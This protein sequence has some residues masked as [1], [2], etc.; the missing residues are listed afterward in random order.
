MKN[1]SEEPVMMTFGGHL[2]VLRKMLFRIMAVVL[3]LGICVF[4]F[5]EDTF[6]ILLAPRKWDFVTYRSIESLLNWMGVE[7]HFSEYHIDLINTELSAQ[8]MTHISSSV[9]LAL[10]GAS[11]YVVYELFCFITPALYERERR[12]SVGIIIATYLLFAVGILMSYF[13]IFP[14]SF[15]FLGTYQV[16]ASIVNTITLSSYISTFTML[17]LIMGLVFQLPVLAFFLAK[18]GLISSCI[19]KK[20]RKHAIVIIMIIAAVITPPDIFTL[21]LVT[22]PIYLLYEVSI[23]IVKRVENISNRHCGQWRDGG[24]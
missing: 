4:A 2:D 17:T 5:K 9:Y 8:F 15:R 24:Q 11:P 3:F 10:L 12:Y 13:I 19:L 6:R 22:I 21:V 16:D 18:I 7:F 20:Y 1:N 14:I 23:F